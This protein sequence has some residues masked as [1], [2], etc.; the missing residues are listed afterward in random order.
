MHAIPYS[1][2]KNK[3]LFYLLVRLLNLKITKDFLDLINDILEKIFVFE[4]DIE[5]IKDDI[6]CKIDKNKITKIIV[7]E[8]VL[9]IEL[10]QPLNNV[11]ELIILSKN[12]TLK[13][14]FRFKYRIIKKITLHEIVY[15]K[16]HVFF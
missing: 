14:F 2:F 3:F 10:K 15:K 11:K 16:Y 1:N 12:I 6:F 8:S 7:P 4:K 5:I 9:S 13:S